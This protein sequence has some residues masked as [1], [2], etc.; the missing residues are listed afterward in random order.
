MTWDAAN[1]EQQT[2]MK[3][4]FE[5]QFATRGIASLYA[6]VSVVYEDIAHKWNVR[7]IPVKKKD[8]NEI[9]RVLISQ[10]LNNKWERNIF[11]R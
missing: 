8:I 7:D 3:V 10:Y 11:T 1:T 9:P 4:I 5:A 2:Q 6:L